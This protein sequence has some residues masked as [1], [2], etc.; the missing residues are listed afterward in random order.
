MH[1]GFWLENFKETGQ[2]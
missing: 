2:P 1:T